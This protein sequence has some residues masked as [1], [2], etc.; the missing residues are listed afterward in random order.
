MNYPL[1]ID[2]V[3]SA[4]KL[5]S[6]LRMMPE[7]TTKEDL[8]H[9]NAALTMALDLIRSMANSSLPGCTCKRYE[10]DD[11][12]WVEPDPN[13]QHH[14]WIEEQ[15]KQIQAKYDE[16]KKRL[17][18]E[19]RI[20]LICAAFSSLTLDAQP[21]NYG[22]ITAAASMAMKLA[23]ETLSRIVEGNEKR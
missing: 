12:T 22:V 10:N 17:S 21:S 14:K 2:R 9:I 18:D 3:T 7:R 4:S 5:V 13:C 16:S 19:V 20:K 23:D 6:D 15:K 1:V 8:S 11:R